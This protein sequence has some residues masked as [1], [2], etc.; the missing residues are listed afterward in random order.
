MF[1]EVGTAAA[2]AAWENKATILETGKKIITL[3]SKG[4][5]TIVVFGSG[6]VG[7]TTLGNLL[8]GSLD[9][10]VKN[11]DYI[12]SETTESFPIKSKVFGSILVPSGQLRRRTVTWNSLFQ[13]MT[14]GKAAGVINVVAWGCHS[15]S[16]L[17]EYRE[18]IIYK[19]WKASHANEDLSVQH[20]TT[21]FRKEKLE[22]EI[23][24]LK[25]VHPH[26]KS[27]KG[28][29]WMITVV[30]KQDLWWDKRHD[31]VDHY[32][33][34]EYDNIIQDIRAHRGHGNFM[35]EYVS[36]S[37][38]CPSASGGTKCSSREGRLVLEQ[39]TNLTSRW[40]R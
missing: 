8:S 3:L 36:A 29:V 16:G 17:A 6:G 19:D 12:E 37:K 25:F 18:H 20:F 22:E 11:I 23:E 21:M 39:I 33:K 5:I 7:K 32:T 2:K 13:R 15:V 31:V 34:G 14:T 30:A 28:N 4:W 27:A 40:P 24:A 26:M 1:V 35:H 9:P 10:E 38:P